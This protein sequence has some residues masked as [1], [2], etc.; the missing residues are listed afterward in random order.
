MLILALIALV[1]ILTTAVLCVLRC[2]ER[3][4]WRSSYDHEKETP[5]AGY[6]TLAHRCAVCGELVNDDDQVQLRGDTIT[7]MAC[8]WNRRA[9]VR[10]FDGDRV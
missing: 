4:A 10:P 3:P 9:T 5:P 7:H 2:L 8:V 6:R 1:L